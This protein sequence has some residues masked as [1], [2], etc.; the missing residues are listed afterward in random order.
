MA[1][2]TP[3]SPGLAAAAAVHG[4]QAPAAAPPAPTL[5]RKPR[6]SHT[7]KKA[8]RAPAPPAAAAADP[9]PPPLEARLDRTLADLAARREAKKVEERDNTEGASRNFIA[10]INEHDRQIATLLRSAKDQHQAI[11][12]Q[13]Q[14]NQNMPSHAAMHANPWTLGITKRPFWKG[15]HIK[16]GKRKRRRTRRKRRRHARR[17]RRR[18]TRRKSRR[19]T[20]R[21]SRR[22]RRRRR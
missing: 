16:G 8:N 15:N 5:R 14:V 18:R 22:R 4:V 2:S 9:R 3:T 7:A 6:R 20:R 1:S 12:R 19:R 21:K 11:H 10:N 13:Q 17:K